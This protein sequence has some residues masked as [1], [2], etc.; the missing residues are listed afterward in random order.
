MDHL[1]DRQH[2]GNSPAQKENP[3]AGGTAQGAARTTFAKR[4][5][6]H[7]SSAVA[8]IVFHILMVLAIAAAVIVARGI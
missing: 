3:L 2:A 4:I 1:N 5:L 7:I 6:S 8:A